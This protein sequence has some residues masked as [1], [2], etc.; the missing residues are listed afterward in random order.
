MVLTA[1]YFSKN[2]YDNSEQEYMAQYRRLTDFLTNY[3]RKDKQEY[4]MFL[5]LS[6]SVVTI[7]K[8][9]LWL[10]FLQQNGVY[11][12]PD[13]MDLVYQEIHLRIQLRT[14][15]IGLELSR[16]VCICFNFVSFFPTKNHESVSLIMSSNEKPLNFYLILL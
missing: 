11:V 3:P 2:W 7:Q 8:S 9:L 15:Q 10:K 5:Q 16:E 4:R 6:V 12:I 14:A 13:I 1:P